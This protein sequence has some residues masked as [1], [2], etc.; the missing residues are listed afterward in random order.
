MFTRCARAAWSAFSAPLTVASQPFNPA[1]EE[2]ALAKHTVRSQKAGHLARPDLEGQ[3]IDP[4]R[5]VAG[6]DALL[7][8]PSPNA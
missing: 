1:L 2:A 6:G 5:I 7:S 4:I 3:V 8:P